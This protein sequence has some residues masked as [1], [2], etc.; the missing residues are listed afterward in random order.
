MEDLNSHQKSVF[1]SW[2]EAIRKWFYPA[3]LIYETSL[4]FYEYA[5]GVSN[6]FINQHERIGEL[7][8]QILAIT[9][10][11][12]TFLI[13]TFYLTLP[14]SI[15]LFKFFKEDKLTNPFLRKIKKYF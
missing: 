15:T 3:W 9:S 4:R 14:A 2:W 1:G 11:V 12:A 10:G 8:A 7:F 6:Y 5:F 13:C